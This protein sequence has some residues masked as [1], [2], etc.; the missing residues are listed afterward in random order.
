MDLHL[1]SESVV[2]GGDGHGGYA[3]ARHHGGDQVSRP[4]RLLPLHPL[5]RTCFRDPHPLFLPFHFPF[6]VDLFAGGGG[7]AALVEDEEDRRGAPSPSSFRG[8]RDRAA[9]G[10]GREQ[11]HVAGEAVG[12]GAR[13]RVGNGDG[14]GECEVGESAGD[15]NRHGCLK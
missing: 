6:V 3:E 12:P 13:L 11:E 15:P 8:N 1:P 5:L 4:L 10:K 14:G 9:V 7:L 2:D